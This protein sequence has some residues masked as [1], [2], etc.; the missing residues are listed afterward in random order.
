MV[1]RR[2]RRG[3][4]EAVRQVCGTIRDTVAPALTC[5]VEQLDAGCPAW[6]TINGLLG[7]LAQSQQMLEGA[8]GDG[9]TAK[10]F[11][12]GDREGDVGDGD[13][14]RADGTEWSWSESHELD[15]GQAQG[16][17][18]PRGW[19]G[20]D[21]CGHGE[22][23]DMG[24]GDW[25]ATNSWRN[26]PTRWEEQGHGKWSRANWADAWEAEHAPLVDE[27]AG[28]PSHKHRRQ[29]ERKAEAQGGGAGTASSVN[30]AEQQNLQRQQAAAAAAA[31]A[32][33]TAEAAQR[34]RQAAE[35]AT[36]LAEARRL[37]TERAAAITL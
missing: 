19:N 12:I 29:E 33:A 20:D 14:S 36:A 3:G 13:G 7:S 5:L 30:E 34:T 21:E 9:A 18:A 2:L 6:Q 26:Q 23:H 16:G 11:D 27:E 24:T 10:S 37:H 25:W 4:D 35:A 22:D 28:E 31:A 32:A 17:D 15:Q 1:P 8:V